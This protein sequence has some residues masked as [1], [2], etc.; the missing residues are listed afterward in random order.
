RVHGRRGE[1]L[2]GLPRRV[3]PGHP[4]PGRLGPGPRAGGGP[5]G[6]TLPVLSTRDL[7]VE[8]AVDGK[9]FP[10]VNRVSFDLAP[11][12]SLGIV[13]ETGCGKTL[14]ASPLLPLPPQRAPVPRP[15]P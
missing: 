11:G 10:A 12:E 7:T 6:L 1:R 5:E 15:L 3:R 8:L 4:L 2:P 14:L 9:W 13:G